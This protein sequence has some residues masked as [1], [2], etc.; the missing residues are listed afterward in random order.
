[1]L[2][3]F[4]VNAV[5]SQAIVFVK[6]EINSEEKLA[7]FRAKLWDLVANPGKDYENF[8]LEKS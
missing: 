1:M 7:D 8:A 3:N 2:P 6:Q 5:I 4:D